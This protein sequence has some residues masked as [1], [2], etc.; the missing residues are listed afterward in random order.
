MSDNTRVKTEWEFIPDTIRKWV[1]HHTGVRIDHKWD[2]SCMDIR[3]VI[4]WLFLTV[5]LEN[6]V[7]CTCHRLQW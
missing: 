3:Y 2:Q 4:C 7:V 1:E 5:L 6:K